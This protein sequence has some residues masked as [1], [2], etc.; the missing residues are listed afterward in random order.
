V[1]GPALAAEGERVALAW[2]TLAGAKA[3]V[4]AALSHD[5][6]GSWSPAV[7]LD[8]AEPLGRVDVVLTPRGALVSWLAG[9]P[10]GAEIRAASLGGDGSPG[11]PAVIARTS[12]ARSSGFPQL[13]RTGREIVAAWTEPGEPA[14]VRTATL[15]VRE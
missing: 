12:A 4:R 11:R 13:E 9:S 14:A 7:T 3:A 1:N 15:E 5:S 6:G 2:Y 8:D 10:E